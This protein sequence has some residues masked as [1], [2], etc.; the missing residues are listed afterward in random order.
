MTDWLTEADAREI[1]VR[2]V[3]ELGT[4]EQLAAI[5]GC[6]HSLISQVLHG[7]R[8]VGKKLGAALGLIA[9]PVTT[10]QYLRKDA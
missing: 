5:A 6:S 3:A 2:K 4:Q 8:P 9:A 7:K 10:F 1:L